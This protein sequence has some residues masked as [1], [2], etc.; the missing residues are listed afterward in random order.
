MF[1]TGYIQLMVNLE[2]H[3]VELKT[4]TVYYRIHT[5]YGRLGNS[6]LL[7]DTYRSW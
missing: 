3:A 5:G 2:T 1:I 7:Q 4:V 6:R